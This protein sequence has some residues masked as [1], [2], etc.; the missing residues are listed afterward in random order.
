ME[1]PRLPAP[2]IHRS[3]QWLA[4]LALLVATTSA[5]ADTARQLDATIAVEH[6]DNVTFG[7]RSRDALS[8]NAGQLRLDYRQLHALDPD[9][10]WGFTTAVDTRQYAEYSRLG[11]VQLEAGPVWRQRFGRGFYAPLLELSLTAA[12]IESRSDLRTGNRWTAAGT[13]RRRMTDRITGQFGLHHSQR[14]ASD[15]DAFDQ[16]RTGLFVHADYLL[17][18]HRTLYG[19]LAWQTGDVAVTA[20][21]GYG[22]DS[23]YG[24]WAQGEADDAFGGEAEDR[25]AFAVE[26]D[27]ASVVV[28]YN[29][30]FNRRNVIDTSIRATRGSVSGG[31]DYDR[32]E[33]RVAYLYR[34]DLR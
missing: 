5:S 25:F 15:S 7:G 16:E 12:R 23:V 2:G 10:A 26:A 19:M 30:G 4:A 6:D 11:E 29:H 1:L 27:L 31:P 20:D 33:L 9:R 24:G 14:R 21:L 18:A 3:V 8:D 34:F 13:L 17:R 28:G 22:G 32:V